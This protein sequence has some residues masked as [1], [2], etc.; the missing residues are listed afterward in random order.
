[1]PLVSQSEPYTVTVAVAVTVFFI[2]Y[3]GSRSGSV[4]YELVVVSLDLKDACMYPIKFPCHR[5]HRTGKLH[6]IR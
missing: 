5:V 6:G 3:A 4:E 2:L 1:M